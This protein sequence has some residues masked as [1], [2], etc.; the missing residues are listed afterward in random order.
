MYKNKQYLD[1]LKKKVYGNLKNIISV[2]SIN[3]FGFKMI[4]Q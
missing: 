1:D 2:F 4:T 3:L